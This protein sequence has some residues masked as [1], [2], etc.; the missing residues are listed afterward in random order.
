M[1]QKQ[2]NYDVTL[3]LREK[4]EFLLLQ[5]PIEYFAIISDKSLLQVNSVVLNSKIEVKHISKRAGKES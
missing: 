4:L 5:P 3:Y 1:Y 2:R